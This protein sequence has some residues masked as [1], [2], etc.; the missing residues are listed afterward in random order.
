MKDFVIKKY[1]N[2]IPTKEECFLGIDV[3][4][5]NCNCGVFIQKEDCWCLALS[6]HYKSQEIESFG[7]FMK[8]VAEYLSEVY[9]FVC[10]K[11]CIAGAGI[12]SNDRSSIIITNLS[13]IINRDEIYSQTTLEKIYLANDFEVMFYG[14]SALD[15]KDLLIVKEGIKCEKATSAIIG[16]GTGFGKSIVIWNESK[17]KP[18]IILSEGGH[19][20]FAAHTAQE[21]ALAEYIMKSENR[22]FYPSWEDVLSGNGVKRIYNFFQKQNCTD[23]TISPHPDEIFINRDRDQS[24]W[25]TYN[26]YT[27]LYGRC[28]KNFALETLC[29][30]GLFIAG[31]IAAR[32][33]EMFSS[34]I[35]L[36]EFF[37]ALHHQKFLKEV[38]L[39]VITDYNV[40]LYG[41]GHYLYLQE[42]KN[43]DLYAKDTMQKL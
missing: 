9:Q 40:S 4:G 20:D 14:I 42:Q 32:N 18:M 5:T 39:T 25:Q 23:S 2:L 22:S 33:R 38:Q 31:G 19:A 29:R 34:S 26:L 15:Q 7:L 43:K 36:E 35:F 1:I 3:G 12:V 17:T 13:F 27:K 30:S 28:A 11:V 37:N 8:K 21:H 41:A 24:S 16:A 10:K 6:L